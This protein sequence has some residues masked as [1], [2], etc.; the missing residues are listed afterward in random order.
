MIRF[1]Y[2]QNFI[3]AFRLM[4]W[5]LDG[6]SDYFNNPDNNTFNIFPYIVALNNVLG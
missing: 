2:V 1:K 4:G 6:Y 5:E 3:E